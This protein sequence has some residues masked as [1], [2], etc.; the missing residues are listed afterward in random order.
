MG[1]REGISTL[2]SARARGREVCRS[3]RICPLPGCCPFR[4]KANS[5]PKNSANSRTAIGSRSWLSAKVCPAPTPA[6]IRTAPSTF[7]HSARIASPAQEGNSLGPTSIPI[8]CM[9]V[10]GLRD[11]LLRP[12]WTCLGRAPQ[13][14]ALGQC[15][16]CPLAGRGSA[17]RT[18]TGPA[19]TLR[20]ILARKLG[21]SR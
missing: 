19:A 12:T 17:L 13:A 11:A 21:A 16:F 1:G 6:R 2:L 7:R 10:H 14:N 9:S 8:G 5:R 15:S 20:R 18:P 3:S 4:R